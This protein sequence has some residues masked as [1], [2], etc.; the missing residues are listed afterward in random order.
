MFSAYPL[1]GVTLWFDTPSPKSVTLFVEA[2]FWSGVLCDGE[3]SAWSTFTLMGGGLLNAALCES[4]VK[5]KSHLGSPSPT[6]V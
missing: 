2:P 5:L 1:D 3:T 4:W 6:V